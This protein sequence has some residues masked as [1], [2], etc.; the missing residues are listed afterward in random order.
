MRAFEIFNQMKSL[1]V[2]PND[3]VISAL[4]YATVAQNDL[5]NALE[6]WQVVETLQLTKTPL[7]YAAM[8]NCIA[9]SQLAHEVYESKSFGALTHGRRIRMASNILKEMRAA[10]WPLDLS[11][12]NNAL[13]VLTMANRV[14][15][16]F[17]FYRAMYAQEGLRPDEHT[18]MALLRM[19]NATRLLQKAERVFAELKQAGITPSFEV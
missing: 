14:H 5:D 19:C 17:D 6:T 7:L 1:G 3:Y 9:R 15:Q 8:L 16:A 18:Y 12:L 4:L 2:K 11:V 13:N 10:G